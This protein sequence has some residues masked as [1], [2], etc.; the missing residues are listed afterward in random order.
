MK[1]SIGLG[2][3]GVEERLAERGVSRRDFL[4]FCTA[5]AVTMGMGP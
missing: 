4:K 3:E 2:K 5:I 1:I